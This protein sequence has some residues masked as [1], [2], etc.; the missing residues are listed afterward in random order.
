MT[1][2]LALAG[3]SLLDM[4]PARLEELAGFVGNSA[5][6]AL[7]EAQR[8]PMETAAFQVPDREPDTTP[9]P[10]PEGQLPVLPETAGLTRTPSPNVAADP[11]ALA[12]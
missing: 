10:V 4:P 7:L 3:A 6:G 8:P 12:V 9:F 5:M 11:A 1:A 2:Q